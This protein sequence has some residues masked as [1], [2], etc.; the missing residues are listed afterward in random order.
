MQSSMDL[1][2]YYDIFLHLSKHYLNHW[3]QRSYV[4]FERYLRINI[5][6]M[7]W[8]SWTL[9]SSRVWLRKEYGHLLLCRLRIYLHKLLRNKE[10]GIYVMSPLWISIAVCSNVENTSSIDIRVLCHI[11]V[12]FQ[13]FSQVSTNNQSFKDI[14]VRC[15]KF[16]VKNLRST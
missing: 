10:E 4:V 3:G 8:N 13:R 6:N 11:L 9:L 14:V 7:I 16:L 15:F 5:K 2:L 1:R 12:T